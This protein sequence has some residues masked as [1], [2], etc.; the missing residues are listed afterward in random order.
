[1]LS[2]VLSAPMA[3]IALHGCSP[4]RLRLLEKASVYTDEALRGREFLSTGKSG[5]T[6]TSRKEHCIMA[7][8]SETAPKGGF[9]QGLPDVSAHTTLVVQQSGCCGTTHQTT[10]SCCGEPAT[11]EIA[12]STATDDC[13][14]EPAGASVS[15]E[16]TVGCCG[17]PATTSTSSDGTSRCC[18]EPI[19]ASAITASVGQSKCC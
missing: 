14:G 16:A 8:T 7:H 4:N 17:E 5:A 18:G 10:G 12:I 6:I 9:L 13:C 19:Q 3:I 2:L 11:H 15:S 1:M